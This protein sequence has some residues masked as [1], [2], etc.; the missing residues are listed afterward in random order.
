MRKVSTFL[1]LFVVLVFLTGCATMTWYKK[2]VTAKSG[3]K[4]IMRCAADS[5][6]PSVNSFSTETFPDWD[7][8]VFIPGFSDIDFNV[9][10]DCMRSKGFKLTSNHE[11]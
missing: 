9:Y 10:K 6:I 4:A 2:G 11:R 7:I 3:R 1:G 8:W 5:G